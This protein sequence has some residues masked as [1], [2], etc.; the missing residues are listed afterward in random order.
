MLDTLDILR[1]EAETDHLRDVEFLQ[2]LCAD[3]IDRRDPH[4]VA[5]RVAAARFD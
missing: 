1:H 3:E 4:A 2:R 5:R